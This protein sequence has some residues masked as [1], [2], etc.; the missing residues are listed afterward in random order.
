MKKND[1][2]SKTIKLLKCDTARII[3]PLGRYFMIIGHKKNTSEDKE[4]QWYK[5][6]EPIDFDYTE[7]RVIANAKTIEGLWK[8]I[9]FYGS[10]PKKWPKNTKAFIKTLNRIVK[11]RKEDK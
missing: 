8:K 6:G 11:K 2:I 5:N 10:L 9:K 4:S 1:V 7:E 3:K